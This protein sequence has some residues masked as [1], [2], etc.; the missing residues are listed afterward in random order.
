MPLYVQDGQ[1]GYEP[2]LDNLIQA[3]LK[4]NGVVSGMAVTAQSS[5]NLSVQVASGVIQ[6]DAVR[7]AVGAT[8]SI[9][10]TAG[11]AS[12]RIDLIYVSSAGAVS[13]VEGTAAASPKP[14]PLPAN[15]ALLAYV[16]VAAGAVNIQNSNITNRVLIIPSVRYAETVFAVGAAPATVGTIR[17]PTAASII[18]RN[19]ANSV[20]LNVLATDGSDQLLISA[21]ALPILFGSAGANMSYTFQ[22][23]PGI[24]AI[25]SNLSVGGTPATTGIVRVPSSSSIP[26]IRA[27][28]GA[29][30]ADIDVLGMDTSNNIYI[31][32][33]FATGATRVNVYG[34]NPVN[35]N[36][37]GS[38]VALGGG[39][40]PTL[41]TIGG[42]GPG[43]AAQNSWL[44]VQI[45]GVD[46][47][48]PVWR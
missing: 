12:P 21:S 27:R 25:A 40:A 24:V 42:S 23:N 11:G 48:I 2:D 19:A 5:P 1:S 9:S 35:F 20:N 44:K 47:Y 16:S 6:W 30:T 33:G 15:S 18:A 29:N 7:I 38:G 4:D 39:A 17:L 34:L 43:T 36:A 13:K 32:G 10:I 3:A 31:G 41:G 22:G 14:P 45:A 28:N 26:T 8:A 46:S 37:T